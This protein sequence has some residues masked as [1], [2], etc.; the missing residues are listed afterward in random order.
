MK[1]MMNLSEETDGKL[2]KRTDTVPVSCDGCGGKAFCC[3]ATD[4]TIILD[5]YDMYELEK[6]QKGGFEAGY[7]K[8]Y[9]LRVV[10]G[11]TLPYLKKAGNTGDCTLLGQDGRC[12]IYANRPGFCRLFPLGRLYTPEGFSYILQTGQCPC[13]TP[14]GS[15]VTVE[16]WLGIKDI[17]EYE[18][19]VQQWHELT[20]RS[21]REAISALTSENADD[22][23]K[24]ALLRNISMKLLKTFYLAPYET[25]MPFYPQFYT[26]F[27]LL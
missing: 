23:E 25:E 8:Y 4:D 12:S 3:K 22:P 10:D 17:E 15:E 27:S 13:N 16:S 21:Q 14:A 18:K 19:Y 20:E 5:P 2:Y 11:I 24:A 6:A 1:R 9:E 7:G 26:R